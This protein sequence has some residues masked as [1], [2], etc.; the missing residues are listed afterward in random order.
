MLA[1]IAVS[2]NFHHMRNVMGQH[3][4]SCIAGIAEQVMDDDAVTYVAHSLLAEELSAEQNPGIHL[5][6]LATAENL[7]KIAGTARIFYLLKN[8]ERFGSLFLGL[9]R[10][11][12]PSLL[13]NLKRFGSLLL[14]LIRSVW[15]SC[16]HSTK[17]AH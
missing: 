3:S 14:G 15:R 4:M 5:Q 11:V 12:W 17:G 16:R 9:I 8:L 13:K 1:S 2:C 10:S 6:L 7:I